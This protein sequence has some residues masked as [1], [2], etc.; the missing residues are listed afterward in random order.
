MKTHAHTN[1]RRSEK[2]LT[3]KY[4]ECLEQRLFYFMTMKKVYSLGVECL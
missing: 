1:I 3:G 2:G 4:N